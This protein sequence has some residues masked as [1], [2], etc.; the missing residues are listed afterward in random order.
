MSKGHVGIRSMWLEGLRQRGA[1]GSAGSPAS[2]FQDGHSEDPP[3]QR[4]PV[5]AADHLPPFMGGGEGGDRFLLQSLSLCALV[6][7]C[8]SHWSGWRASV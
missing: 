4:L 6:A 8:C 2:L 3:S 5:G 7:V 1:G